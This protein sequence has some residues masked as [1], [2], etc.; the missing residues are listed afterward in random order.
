MKKTKAFKPKS[1]KE[2]FAESIKMLKPVVTKS[3]PLKKNLLKQLEKLNEEKKVLIDLAQEV[4][5]KNMIL[6][7]KKDK[8]WEQVTKDVKAKPTQKLRIDT[9][10]LTVDFL[11]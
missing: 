6:D 9:K 1:L 8:F 2:V 5:D 10:N 11:A 4:V 3:V 7:K